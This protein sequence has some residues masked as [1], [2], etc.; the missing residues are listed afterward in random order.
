MYA[1][2]AAQSRHDQSGIVREDQSVGERRIVERFPKGVLG[3]R[4]R[5][6]VEGWKGTKP[7]QQLELNWRN[8]VIRL[9]W[10][11]VAGEHHILTEFSRIR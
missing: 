5:I 10:R 7:G 4:R 3:K 8:I 9:V 1:G 6:L 11:F 2:R